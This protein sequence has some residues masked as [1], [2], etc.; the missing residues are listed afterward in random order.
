MYVPA[1]ESKAIFN[2]WGSFYKTDKG[3]F[4]NSLDIACKLIQKEDL[5]TS[6]VDA[7]VIMLNPGS[8]EP[9]NQNKVQSTRNISFTETKPDPAQYQIMS[10]MKHHNWKHVRILNLSDLRDPSS[11]SFLN[12]IKDIGSDVHSIF[13]D[14]RVEEFNKLY[15]I[16]DHG[17]TVLA[18]TFN[19]EISDLADKALNKKLINSVGIQ[20]PTL[21]NLFRYPSP[22]NFNKKVEWLEQITEKIKSAA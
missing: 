10:L 5:L 3:S 21:K 8:S 11:S 4:R 1:E 7:V 9:I 2:V 19:S 20:H 17:W 22:P 16:K 12:S 13:S 15:N 14:S 6:K 18:W